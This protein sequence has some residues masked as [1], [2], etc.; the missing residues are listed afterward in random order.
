M[1]VYLVCRVCACVAYMWCGSI[2][3]A[4]YACRPDVCM[5]GVHVVVSGVTYMHAG[6]SW[7]VYAPRCL[8]YGRQPPSD[9]AVHCVSGW[10]HQA[11][12]WTHTHLRVLV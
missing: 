3:C 12:I 11:P 2:R 6:A 8:C 10:I 9:P 5:C 7:C 1:V 4:V